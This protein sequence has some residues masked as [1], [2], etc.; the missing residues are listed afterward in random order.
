VKT[1]P[2]VD[3]FPLTTAINDARN[4]SSGTLVVERVS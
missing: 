4:R 1:R 2:R 3:E